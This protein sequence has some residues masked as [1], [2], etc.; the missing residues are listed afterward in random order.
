[1]KT[2]YRS[3]IFLLF[4]ALTL[5]CCNSKDSFYKGYREEDLFRMPLHKPYQ[6]IHIYLTDIEQGP[7]FH[8]WALK[9][10]YADKNGIDY[11]SVSATH[12]NVV[13]GIIYGYNPASGGYP[14]SWFV[15]IPEKKIEKEFKQNKE[16]WEAYLKAHGIDTIK[17]YPVWETFME[18]KEK[19]ILPWRNKSSK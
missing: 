13:S 12:I 17:L 14:S 8:W 7:K 3:K 6:L 10:H 2:I 16:E 4:I 9:L 18:F 5:L 15:I 19:G 11:P 1:M